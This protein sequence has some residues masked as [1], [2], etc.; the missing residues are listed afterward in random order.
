MATL[1]H[2][3][4]RPQAFHGKS[5]GQ[6][7]VMHGETRLCS[8]SPHQARHL[9]SHSPTSNF[10]RNP[11]Q[12]RTIL[13]KHS[14][15][16]SDW[17]SMFPAHNPSICS[18]SG[19]GPEALKILHSILHPQHICIATVLPLVAGSPGANTSSSGGAIEMDLHPL[20]YLDC[21][22]TPMHLALGLV[23]LSPSSCTQPWHLGVDLQKLGVWYHA[24][25]LSILPSPA[26]QIYQRTI[27]A[28]SLYW[29]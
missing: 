19:Q 7:P 27:Y 29:K 4:V 3:E 9:L 10:D 28:R 22:E 23:P 17:T 1:P 5:L 8:S 20:R 12:L 2:R 15:L 24:L 21:Q 11:F 13:S 6:A 26:N 25:C 14:G 18:S 16:K